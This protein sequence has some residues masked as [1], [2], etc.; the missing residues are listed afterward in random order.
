MIV[1]DGSIVPDHLDKIKE[2]VVS[3]EKKYILLASVV[4]D[5]CDIDEDVSL[6][7]AIRSIYQVTENEMPVE[8][9]KMLDNM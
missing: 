1:N 5:I 6:G 8:V 4:T 2:Y 9:K 7:E 3:L